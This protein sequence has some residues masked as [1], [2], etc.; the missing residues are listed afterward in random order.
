MLVGDPPQGP[1]P[2]G[3]A[4]LGRVPSVAEALRRAAL[5]VLPSLQEGFGIVVAE[6]L[7]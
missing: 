7:A 1:L 2:D 3:V 6:A 5:L 4:A